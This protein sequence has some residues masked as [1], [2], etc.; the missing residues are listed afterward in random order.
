MIQTVIEP[1]FREVAQFADDQGVSCMIECE[2]GGLQPRAMFCIRPSGHSMR[3][4][5][6]PD[7]MA[8]REI[9]GVYYRP[10]GQRLVW[11]SDEE[12]KRQLTMG[13][14]RAAAAAIVQDHFRSDRDHVWEK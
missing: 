5:L 1:A 6:D 2:L 12:L 4:E 14:A 11:V 3:Y 10:M 9:E 8:V 7:G 13:Y